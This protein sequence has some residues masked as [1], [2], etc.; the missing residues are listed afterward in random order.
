[1]QHEGTGLLIAVSEDLKG[2]Y[3]HGR[4]KAELEHNTKQAIKDILEV[5][6]GVNIDVFKDDNLFDKIGALQSNRIHY[7]TTAEQIA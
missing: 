7:G 4:D 5:K 3:V 1:M 2:L 6:F